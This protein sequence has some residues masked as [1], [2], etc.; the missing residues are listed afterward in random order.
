M[1]LAAEARLQDVHDR[2]RVSSGLLVSH[3]SRLEHIHRA[4]LEPRFGDLQD[5]FEAKRVVE[6]QL[7]GVDEPAPVIATC[8]FEPCQAHAVRPVVSGGPRL[9]EPH[10]RQV[11]QLTRAGGAK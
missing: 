2:L 5:L 10:A 11:E 7:D 3:L 9:C 8:A 4:G 6:R 1:S